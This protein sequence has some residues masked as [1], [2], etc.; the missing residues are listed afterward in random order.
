MIMAGYYSGISA[1]SLL[2]HLIPSIATFTHFEL[3]LKNLQCST[4]KGPLTACKTHILRDYKICKTQETIQIFQ[5][6]MI[7]HS[8]FY[9]LQWIVWTQKMSKLC[10]VEIRHRHSKHGCASAC[11]FLTISFDQLFAIEITQIERLLT[12]LMKDFSLCFQSALIIKGHFNDLEYIAHGQ[13]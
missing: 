2:N 13:N 8:L 5:W 10:A 11:C 7:H 12:V 4:R 1:K 3:R 6:S 9:P